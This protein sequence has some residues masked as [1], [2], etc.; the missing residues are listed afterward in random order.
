MLSCNTL[1]SSLFTLTSFLL[2][3]SFLSLQ[4]SAQFSISILVL[5]T[6]PPLRT[7]L[8]IILLLKYIY[9]NVT[10]VW[11]HHN[12]EIH[13]LAV[14]R[15]AQVKL[16]LVGLRPQ[17][18]N[19]KFDL[20]LKGSLRALAPNQWVQ[21]RSFTHN[22]LGGS[23]YRKLK[24]PAGK[25]VLVLKFRSFAWGW[26]GVFFN[27]MAACVFCSVLICTGINLQEF[28]RKKN[29]IPFFKL[30]GKIKGKGKMRKAF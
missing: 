14:R 19:T 2:A 8:R 11:L 22:G 25:V 15:P 30:Q 26:F 4:F 24:S 9:I 29:L 13:E 23:Q 21:I 16:L 12:A 5:S 10:F 1:I 27:F 28:L 6:I 7:L 3:S 20:S 18:L 17:A